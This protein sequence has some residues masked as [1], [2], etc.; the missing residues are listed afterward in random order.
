MKDN[1]TLVF[2]Q[3]SIEHTH[4][5]TEGLLS[6]LNV[7]MIET[8]NRIIYWERQEQRSDVIDVC[9]YSERREKRT[10]ISHSTGISRFIRVERETDDSD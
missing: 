9:H 5:Y 6:I 2:R 7:F 3:V 8:H 1:D 4:T 10:D